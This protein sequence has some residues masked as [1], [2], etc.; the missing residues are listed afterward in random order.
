MFLILPKFDSL[1]EEACVEVSEAGRE[2]TC[3]RRAGNVWGGVGDTRGK[4]NTDLMGL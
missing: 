3:E 1:Y 4:T 2:K